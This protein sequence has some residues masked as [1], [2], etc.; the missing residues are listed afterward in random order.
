MKFIIF[1]FIFLS[2]C[3]LIAKASIQEPVFEMSSD[4]SPLD[5]SGQWLFTNIDKEIFKDSELTTYK[6][7]SMIYAPGG[8]PELNDK[9]HYKVGWY[10]AKIKFPESMIGQEV[11]LLLDSYISKVEVFM[12]GQ[13][14]FSR[15]EGQSSKPFYAIQPIPT[16]FKVTKNIHTLSIRINTI[17]MRGVYQNPF[18]LRVSK[19][20]DF[21]LFFTYMYTDHLKTFAGFLLLI[22]G[23]FFALLYYKT[24]IKIYL[25]ASL[26]GLGTFPYFGFTHEVF[27][28][29]FN[30]NNILLLHYL[31]ILSMALFSNYFCQYLYKPNKKSLLAFTAIQGGLALLFV[32]QVFYFNF[33]LF[34]IIR[35]LCFISSFLIAGHSFYVFFKIH[36]NNH[37]QEVNTRYIFFAYFIYLSFALHDIL[38]ALGAF[39]SIGLLFFGNFILASAIIWYSI[40]H[41]THIFFTNKKLVNNLQELTYKLESK[42]EKRTQELKKSQSQLVEM[43]HK[44]GMAEVATSVLHNLGNA[45]NT[46]STYT[47]KIMDIIKASPVS[48]LNK[49]NSLVF[50]KYRSDFEKSVQSQPKL[51]TLPE[52]Y[53]LLAQELQTDYKNLSQCCE[54]L[55]ENVKKVSSIISYQKKYTGHNFKEE[56][57]IHNLIKDILD[58]HMVLIEK[59]QISTTVNIPDYLIVTTEKNKL[60]HALYN[61][62]DN[63]IG[64]LMNKTT[65]G[66][67]LEITAS[68][69]SESVRICVKDNGVGIAKQDLKTI[70][71]QGFTT[72][73]QG[74]GLGLHV[75]YNSI[76]EIGGEIKV[77]SDGPHLGAEFQII[78]PK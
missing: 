6:G 24:K 49:L 17:L 2:I 68:E 62:I 13:R 69:D 73:N 72:K 28:K 32:S 50:D 44:A 15:G 22:F 19:P 3:P 21:K 5:L 14:I 10:R 41:F 59:Y 35:K 55:D 4:E 8:W 46:L 47:S 1:A 18:Q 77:N 40:Q 56:I 42:V 11:V 70:F 27:F 25:M 53:N 30:Y 39:S 38:L 66:N 63:A 75:T 9:E 58:S 23:V 12:D 26:L 37:N 7:W 33:E 43:A 36:K 76:K 60:F 54:Q 20:Y 52:A 71:Y 74:T 64:A 61:V 34:L 45:T 67:R 51:K 16:K 31:G 29:A 65:A 78:L 48:E 57:N